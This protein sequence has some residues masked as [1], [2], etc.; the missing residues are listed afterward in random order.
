MLFFATETM[1]GLEDFCCMSIELIILGYKRDLEY[2]VKPLK[3]RLTELISYSARITSLYDLWIVDSKRI[4]YL[5]KDD[6]IFEIW[7]TWIC[8]MRTWETWPDDTNERV[9]YGIRE[10]LSI[11]SKWKPWRIVL[12]EFSPIETAAVV[13][14]YFEEALDLGDPEMLR[15]Q[16]IAAKL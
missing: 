14:Q 13:E 16:I 2:P 15:Y 11:K 10:V 1:T 5:F 9:M 4:H 3:A 6:E 8:N 12:G 7:D